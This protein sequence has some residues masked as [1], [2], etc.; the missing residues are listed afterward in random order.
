MCSPE[1]MRNLCVI[2]TAQCNL[3][4]SYCYQNAKKSRSMDWDT[5]ETALELVLG[6][7]HRELKVN[8]VG[9]E[10]LLE[11]PMISRAVE[12]I[13]EKRAPEKRVNYSISTNG[14]LLKTEIAAFFA[15]HHFDTQISFDGIADAQNYRGPDTFYVLDKML[16]RLRREH[17]RFYRSCLTIALTLTSSNIEFLAD[18]VDYFMTKGVMQ[19]SISPIITPDFGWRDELIDELDAQYD[20]IYESS[21]R[22]YR[23]TGDIPLKIFQSK[24]DGTPGIS[25][26]SAMCGVVDGESL[27]VDVDGQAYGCTVLAGSYQETDS[28]FL[29]SCLDPLRMGSI[30][31]P[32]FAKCHA[33]F[34]EAIRQVRLFHNKE[35]K[36]SSYGRCGECPYIAQCSVCPIS[37]GHVPG[38]SDPNRVSD[39][40]CAYNLVSRRYRE[41]FPSRPN[42]KD[43][44]ACPPEVSDEMRRWKT[45]A[46]TLKG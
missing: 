17:P 23:N 14:T 44:I 24:Y 26:R 41:R 34:P 4:C 22:R 16:D 15:K 7:Q 45:L 10:P 9:G 29:R 19:I 12:Y 1:R 42:P 33:L 43:L 39:L 6:S 46:E 3:R 28:Q 32:E 36:Y 37:I 2:L 35:N 8:F 27:V 13:E 40:V 38:N 18:S 20:R 5:L 21:L 30:N 31:D 25:K 11:F